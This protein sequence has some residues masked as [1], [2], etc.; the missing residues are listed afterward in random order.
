MKWF[1]VALILVFLVMTASFV[2][3]AEKLYSYN[4]HIIPI[5]DE[6]CLGCHC[7]SYRFLCTHDSMMEYIS[8]LRESTKGVPLVVP[9][10]PDSSV[11][12]WRLEGKLPNGEEIDYMPQG[13]DKLPEEK[14]QIYREWIEQGAVKSIVGVDDTK[15]W[16]QIKKM[17][18]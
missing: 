3:R 2:L 11:V 7:G 6:N 17:F 13:S 1:H 10:K 18:K 5:N 4:R 14:R 16:G 12:I 15:K 8:E 9:G